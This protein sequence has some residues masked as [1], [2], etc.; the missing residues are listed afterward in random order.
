M[1]AKFLEAFSGKFAE[2]W[3]ATL[4]TPAFIFWAGGAIA[5]WQKL[6]WQNLSS[7]FILLPESLQIA[8]LFG[9]F[10]IVSL[11]ALTIQRFDILII[12][13][14]EGYW[15][16]KIR[17]LNN[18]LV[19]QS[20]NQR[21]QLIEQLRT[22]NNLGSS[23]NTQQRTL[24]F[25]C[26]QQFRYFPDENELLPTRLG[27]ILRSAERRPLK[28]YG[29]DAIICWTH[30]WL[31]LPDAAR[32]D[33]STA[34]SDLNA[35][36]RAWIWSILFM[37]WYPIFGAQWAVS[38]AIVALVIYNT[39]I[40]DAARTYADLITAA[41]DTHRHLLYKSLRFPLP[42]RT[43]TEPQHGEQLTRYLWRDHPQAISLKDHN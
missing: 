18:F 38:G 1:S 22:L 10:L 39:W 15:F 21:S 2:Q 25:Q 3:I 37:V 24:Y 11:S 33:L 28:R 29:L 5:A 31:L 41:F 32:T 42:D 7:W 13:F 34:R 36:A 8:S 43:D 19:K 12:Q 30:L 40:L 9:I 6:G 20:R 27:N 35:A 4:L 16:Q 14:L 17:G 26:D 23:M